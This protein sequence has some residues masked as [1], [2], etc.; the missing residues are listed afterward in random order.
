MENN[1]YDKENEFVNAVCEMA[2][3]KGIENYMLL[4]ESIYH[5]DATDEDFNNVAC[6][7]E[8]VL[9]DF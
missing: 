9:L 2:K 4:T 8:D 7:V 1:Y 5:I 6:E 3:E